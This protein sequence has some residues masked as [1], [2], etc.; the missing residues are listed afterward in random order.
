M[1]IALIAPFEE[2][3]PPK[4]YGGTEWI[5]Y[6]LAHGLGQKGH[7]VDL[8]ASGDSKQEPFYRLIPIV[9]QSLRLDQEIAG[10]QRIREM[11]KFMNYAKVVE[12]LGE[13]QYDLVHNHA[14]WRLLV[15]S[16][17]IKNKI[18]STHHGPL[19]LPSYQYI[20]N[21]YQD[22]SFVSIS[23]NQRKPLP[24]LNWVGTVYN[25]IDLQEFPFAQT[26]SENLVFLARFSPEKGP[27]QAA[28]VARE[29]QKKL[30]MAA[31]VDSVDKDYFEKFKPQIDNKLINFVGEIGPSERLNYLQNARC[32]LAPIQWEEPF[33]LFFTEA[34]ACGTPVCAFARGSVPEI[35]VDG[36]TGFIVNSSETDQ[37]GDWIIKKTGPEGIKEAVEKIYALPLDQYQAM[38]RASRARVEKL[39]TVQRMV[40][41]YEAVYQ[42]ILSSSY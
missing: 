13:N 28:Q 39:F 26:Q 9:A 32:L 11:A 23:N 31:K 22:S 4:K 25:G 14:G 42:K 27:Y 37:R 16:R 24:N 35:V 2:S 18:V 41:G 3:V 38:R 34:M 17:P 33:G 40:D 21:Q 8:Y 19:N 6:H 36:E 10:D 1:K 30:I 5:V 12:K 7:Q 15:F 20:Y 29:L